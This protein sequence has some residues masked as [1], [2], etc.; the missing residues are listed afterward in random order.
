[1]LLVGTLLVFF[2][3][4]EI[5]SRIALHPP[6]DIEL[7]GVEQY[8]PNQSSLNE[9]PVIVFKG[10]HKT[11]YNYPGTGARLRPNTWGIIKD[12]SVSHRTV[13]IRTNALGYRNREI[14]KK[15]A[16]RILVLGDSITLADYV[17]ENETYVRQLE[18]ML[19]ESG[20]DV[21][22]INAGVG[23]INLAEE[24]AILLETG[25]SVD[26][27][28]VLIGLYLNDASESFAFQT[29]S[30]GMLSYSRFLS[31]AVR[32]IEKAYRVS[33]MKRRS[34]QPIDKEAREKFA[35]ANEHADGITWRKSELRLNQMII[36]DWADWGYA[37]SGN[38]WERIAGIMEEFQR[39][40]KE[41]GFLVV[42]VLFPVRYQV[43]SEYLNAVP[44]QQ[45]NATMAGLGIPHLDLLP[46]LRQAYRTANE[47]PYYDHAHYTVPGNQV[48]AGLISAFLAP[49]AQ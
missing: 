37:W 25:R 27:D 39:I 3:A 11:L 4:A 47:S 43:E 29:S 38:A 31:W 21:E 23:A 40:G 1:M 46:E 6:Q 28:M 18:K 22:V 2:S 5:V 24:F 44:Q 49:L 33:L 13:D 15:N 26:P 30:L 7:V 41:D 45:F 20:K 42:V 48:V 32:S 36:D 12:H 19:Q 16:T 9:E 35:Q 14:G 8:Q 34:L 10:T 17:Q